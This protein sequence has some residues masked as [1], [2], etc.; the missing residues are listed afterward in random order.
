MS[1]NMKSARETPIN[2]SP[3]GFCEKSLLLR[4]SAPKNIR[5]FNFPSGG[6]QVK[7][8]MASS[9]T[10]LP[11]DKTV[12]KTHIMERI[13]SSEIPVWIIN[14][15]SRSFRWCLTWHSAV[16]HDEQGFDDDMEC[17]L[18]NC[19][20]DTSSDDVVVNNDKVEW[21]RSNC[22]PKNAGHRGGEGYDCR[23]L[24]D[25]HIDFGW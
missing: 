3:R 2:Q 22:D 1:E 14:H 7:Y 6:S 21:K 9:A 19:Y 23:S 11:I 4:L 24:W 13:K 5:Y 18:Q 8:L 20:N 16:V 25:A 12:T 17:E 15:L 10:M